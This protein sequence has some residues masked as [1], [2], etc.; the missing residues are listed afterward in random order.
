M[1]KPKVFKFVIATAELE[2][3]AARLAKDDLAGTVWES[4]GFFEGELETGAVIEIAAGLI[5]ENDLFLLIPKILSDYSQISAYFTT[6]GQSP[7]LLFADGSIE[8]I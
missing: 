5:E 1:R 8:E 6:D 3:I 7:K 4:V 2:D